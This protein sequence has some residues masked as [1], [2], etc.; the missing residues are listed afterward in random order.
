MVL[1][2][3]TISISKDR[4]KINIGPAIFSAK[5]QTQISAG[6]SNIAL[7][8]PKQINVLLGCLGKQP[9]IMQAN[10]SEGLGGLL[11]N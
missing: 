6:K 11:P 10:T 4:T 5:P 7:T 2:T 1:G 9:G 8:A 3:W